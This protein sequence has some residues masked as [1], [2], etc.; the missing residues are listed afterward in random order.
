MAEMT[1]RGPIHMR[2]PQELILF[3]IIIIF[4]PIG[5]LS[6]V[7]EEQ[8]EIWAG[9]EDDDEDDEDGLASTRR[10]V[11]TPGASDRL[12]RC[13]PP[14]LLGHGCSWSSFGALAI[15][16]LRARFCASRCASGRS[17]CSVS[18]TRRRC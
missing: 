5:L 1:G 14:L 7:R 13:P 11:P 12:M 16:R 9:D 4:I 18:R 17:R 10:L 15:W 3:F 2:A 8:G 6:F